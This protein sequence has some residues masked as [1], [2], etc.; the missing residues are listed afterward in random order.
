MGAAIFKILLLVLITNLFNKEM[1]QGRQY[2]NFE[3]NKIRYEMQLDSLVF[4]ARNAEI[5]DSILRIDVK[6]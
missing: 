4:N 2:R 1:K 5:R 3:R 6:N